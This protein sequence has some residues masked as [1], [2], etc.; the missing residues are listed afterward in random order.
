[1]KLFYHYKEFSTFNQKKLSANAENTK[2]TVGVNGNIVNGTGSEIKYQAI[3]FIQDT[4][5]IW[6]HGTLY[7]GSLQ[8]ITNLV[9]KDELK[10]Y[11]Q[12][13]EH[14]D[15]YKVINDVVVAANAFAVG[16]IA[17]GEGGG[18]LMFEDGIIT[19][20]IVTPQYNFNFDKAIR[21]DDD[22][23]LVYTTG[24]TGEA[25]SRVISMDG[26]SHSQYLTSDDIKGKVDAS[27]L[28]TVATS[29]S[30]N[31]LSNKPSIPTADTVAGWGYTKNVGTVT[32][33]KVNGTTV[34]DKDGVAN[35]PVASTSTY[36][37]TK[38][39]NGVDSSSSELA[40]TPNAVKTAYETAK[41]KQDKLVS[42]TNIKTVNGYDMLG[43]GN[44]TVGNIESVDLGG[45][46]DEIE[47]DTFVK[48]VTQSLTDAQKTQTRTNI[49]AASKKV[50]EEWE[51]Y[52][53]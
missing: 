28:A 2:Y 12:V 42:G 53:G 1:M 4:K 39:Y 18:V 5:Q 30:Y 40:A 19:S 9:N 51:W 22:G 34:T 43:S 6:T 7:D 23:N 48:F 10:N 26:H 37:A 52:E 17:T 21:V 24:I 15:G 16:D 25:N 11:L 13:T 33:V 27:D 44:I 46:I 50:E 45:T 14:E 8:D 49:Y 38:L 41:A 35:V 3:V 32:D 47:T 29:G 31:D 20:G 36:G